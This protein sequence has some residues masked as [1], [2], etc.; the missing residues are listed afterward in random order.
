[1]SFENGYNKAWIIQFK[2]NEIKD[3]VAQ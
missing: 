2:N 1:M 3:L